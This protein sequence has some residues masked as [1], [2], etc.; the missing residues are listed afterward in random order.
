MA[1]FRE[2]LEAI[3]KKAERKMEEGDFIGE[4][5]LVHC[6]KC[7]GAR[8]VKLDVFGRERIV[9]CICKC[10]QEAMEAEKRDMEARES[11]K[12]VARM[13]REG[14]PEA[15]YSSWTFDND[16]E[17]DPHTM[18]VAK[19]YA[20]HF[21]ELAK[22]GQGLVFHGGMGTGKT[23]ASACIA[24]AVMEQ[25]Y[26]VLMTNM[27]RIYNTVNSTWENRQSDIDRLM[28]YDLLIIDDLGVERGSE[29][30]TETVYAVID[31]RYKA[32]KPMVVSTNL[33]IEELKSTSDLG[34]ARIYQRMLERCYPVE[35]KGPNRRMKG[36][37]DNFYRMRDLLEP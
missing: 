35:V 17:K 4:D 22:E 36:M 7:G 26:S 21:S 28:R 37:T 27:S 5:G 18:G 30:V 6:G 3:E 12:K 32:N 25:G 19:R 15:V 14:F 1:G 9:W 10:E 23:Y 13:K 34:R 29:H 24:N 8:Q 2:A 20:A 33:T 16:D 31:G 11:A